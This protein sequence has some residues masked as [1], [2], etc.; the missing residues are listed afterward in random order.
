[1]V[2]PAPAS[3]PILGGRAQL[4]PGSRRSRR[5]W[6]SFWPAVTVNIDYHL[7]FDDH[8]Y[9][10]HYTHY[11]KGQRDMEVR[12]AAT[13]V[14]IFYAGRR[15]TSHVRSFEK[16]R[17]TTKPE[18]RPSSHNQHLEWTPS[19]IIA[20]GKSIGPNTGAVLEE[21]LRRRQ[22]PE[23]GYR[24]CLGVIRL[25]DRY[26]TERLERACARALKYGT[27]NRRSIDAILRNHLDS[28]P[29]GA[30]PPQLALPLHGNI[31]G[32]GYYH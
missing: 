8:Y 26:P 16:Y 10:V 27:L 7:E 21:I 1:M 14:E 15:V 22:H 11:S 28:E 23:Q 25:H 29:D 24:S 20:W 30:E 19:R 2:A 18:H 31:R 9:S 13:T 17:H 3:A 4:R 5:N 32:A 12:A 6:I